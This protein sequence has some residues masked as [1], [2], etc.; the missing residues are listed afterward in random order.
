MCKNKETYIVRS[1]DDRKTVLAIVKMSQG[2]NPQ[3]YTK[4]NDV[5][6]KSKLAELYQTSP[7]SIITQGDLDREEQIYRCV[8]CQE[9]PVDALG[10]YDTCPDCI[11]KI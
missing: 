5:A 10:G 1:N 6:W 7:E 3:H 8:V 9:N 4:V 11:G 2:L